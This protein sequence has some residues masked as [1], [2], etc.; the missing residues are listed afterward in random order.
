MLPRLLLLVDDNSDDE[1]LTRRALRRVEEC[2]IEVVVARDGRAALDL[3]NDLEPVRRLPRRPDLV[4]LDLKMP[5]LSGSEV[6]ASLRANPALRDLPVVVFT[7][8]SEEQDRRTSLAL[9]ASDFVS[10][11]VEYG[12]FCD[13]VVAILRRWTPASAEPPT[14][15]RTAPHGG[16]S[17]ASVETPS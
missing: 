14:A 5:R 1:A 3:L 4:L 16:T 8:S 2:S 15:P 6:L 12:A 10:K 13:A 7:S 17:A 11:P 9:G